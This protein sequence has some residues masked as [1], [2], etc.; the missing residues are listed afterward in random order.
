MRNRLAR[1]S[2]PGRKPRLLAQLVRGD[3][4]EGPVSLDGNGFEAVRVDGVIGS[5]PQQAEAVLLQILDQVTPFDGHDPGRRRPA[6]KDR[7]P[8]G[9]PILA[10]GRP[11]SFRPG[12][13]AASPGTPRCRY[14]P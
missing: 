8:A 11:G 10:A 7:F 12:R 5:F 3:P 4:I 1:T 6:R 13:R 14:P 9:S 2:E